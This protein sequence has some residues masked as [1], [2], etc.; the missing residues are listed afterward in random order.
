MEIGL[1]LTNKHKTE[2]GQ[3]TY[4][5]DEYYDKYRKKELN[6]IM[7]HVGA[8]TTPGISLITLT[9]LSLSSHYSL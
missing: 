3:F 5:T 2:N 9:G 7:K 6:K 8:I 4:D 1:G